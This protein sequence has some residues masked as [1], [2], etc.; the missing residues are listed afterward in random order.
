MRE[1]AVVSFLLTQVRKEQGALHIAAFGM[2]AVLVGVGQA[3]AGFK[4]GL[5]RRASLPGESRL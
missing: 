5:Y 1:P 4:P 3:N 2:R